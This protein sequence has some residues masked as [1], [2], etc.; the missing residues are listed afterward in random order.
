M[1]DVVVLT[2]DAAENLFSPAAKEFQ[3][4]REFTINLANKRTSFGKPLARTVHLIPHQFPKCGI[5]TASFD[6]RF[7]NPKPPQIVQRQVNASFS[8]INRNVLP[9]IRKLQRGAGEV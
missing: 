8:V 3:I 7:A 5:E 9:E 1:K 2:F 6:I 4:N